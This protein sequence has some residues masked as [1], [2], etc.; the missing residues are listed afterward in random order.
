MIKV[1][2]YIPLEGWSKLTKVTKRVTGRTES[3]TV[4]EE[5]WNQIG[6]Q[7]GQCPLS[8]QKSGRS[9]LKIKSRYG[10]DT[11]SFGRSEMSS[12]ESKEVCIRSLCRRR[13]V[14]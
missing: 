7:R 8:A 14:S 12:P 2:S 9:R 6:W 3:L 1:E 11:H 4:S 5:W 13:R 10:Q